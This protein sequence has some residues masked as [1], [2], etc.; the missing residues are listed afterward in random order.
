MESIL[1]KL[2][3]EFS[4]PPP[5]PPMTTGSVRAPVSSHH[6]TAHSNRS[7]PNSEAPSHIKPG[8]RWTEGRVFMLAQLLAFKENSLVK[9]ETEPQRAGPGQPCPGS[10]LE[11]W[12]LAWRDLHGD[13]SV[14]PG[15][16]LCLG[17]SLSPALNISLS[18]FLHF[19]DVLKLPG[20][21]WAV[22]ELPCL[23][24]HG[25][26]RAFCVCPGS[27]SSNKFESVRHFSSGY[28]LP[29]TIFGRHL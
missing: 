12:P 20:I 6:S 1:R 28:C 22:S 26:Q 17:E 9:G 16:F 3:P 19:S 5:A 27:I 11:L 21:I 2:L 15:G 25:E 7:T 13:D 18:V 8:I 10:W 4:S 14:V 29:N 24:G 23:P